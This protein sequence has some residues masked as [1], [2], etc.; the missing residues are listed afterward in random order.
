MNVA[1]EMVASAEDYAILVDN[2]KKID[3]LTKRGIEKL[4][5]SA[6]LPVYNDLLD[7]CVALENELRA[8]WGSPPSQ[9]PPDPT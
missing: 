9:P 4:P 3:E 7:R 1:R 6:D 2:K 8:L 5:T